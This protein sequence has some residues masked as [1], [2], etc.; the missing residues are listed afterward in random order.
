MADA[1]R[2]DL[3]SKRR[4]R[5]LNLSEVRKFILDTCQRTRPQL[6]LTRVS[7]ESFDK[8]EYWLRERIRQ[9]VHRHP[10][11]GKTFRL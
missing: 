4:S 7:A 1:S 8:L 9:E 10:S 11:M 5:L 6:G 2:Q 3:D